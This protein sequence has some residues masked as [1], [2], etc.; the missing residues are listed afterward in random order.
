MGWLRC[1]ALGAFLAG[2][3]VSAAALDKPALPGTLNYVEGQASIGT[4]V[5]NDKSVGSAVLKSG[6][7]LTTENGNVEVVLAPNIFLRVGKNSSVQMISGSLPD[8]E[9]ALKQGRAMVEVAELHKDNDVRVRQQGSTTRLLKTGLYEFDASQRD[10]RVYKGEAKVQEGDQS[11]KLKSGREVALDSGGELKPQKFD[12]KQAENSNLYR[13]NRLRSTYLAEAN[14]QPLYW[15]GPAWAGW[16][17][18]PAWGWGPGWG[19]W[20][21]PG[22]GWGWR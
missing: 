13:F 3:V 22:W 1:C 17:W 11:V 16:G 10:I 15:Y 2:A 14:P 19:G 7:R 20:W 4:Q 21:A 12:K 6:Q 9:V 18:G 8:T 5:L